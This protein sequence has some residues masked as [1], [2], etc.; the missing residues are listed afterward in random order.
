MASAAK[1][2]VGKAVVKRV[3]GSDPGALTSLLTA[4]MVGVAA[5]VLAYRLLRS[6]G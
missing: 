2:T 3:S 6:G 1:R 5:A 4:A